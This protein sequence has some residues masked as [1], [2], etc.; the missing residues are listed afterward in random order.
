MGE[1]NSCLSRR[2]SE[3]EKPRFIESTTQM[4]SMWISVKKNINCKSRLADVACHLP[5]PANCKGSHFHK[6]ETGLTPTQI[7]CAK[8]YL[9]STMQK[10][11]RFHGNYST[12]L[13]LFPSKPSALWFLCEGHHLHAVI[14]LVA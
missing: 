12:P 4:H 5:R 6:S 1:E 2:K 13:P 9:I 10:Q 7:Q 3:H 8:Q 14:D 11:K